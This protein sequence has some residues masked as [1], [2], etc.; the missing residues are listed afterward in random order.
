MIT[1]S[2]VGS[3]IHNITAALNRQWDMYNGICI[4]FN[5]EAIPLAK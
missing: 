3:G 5:S 4:N 2:Q 1:I